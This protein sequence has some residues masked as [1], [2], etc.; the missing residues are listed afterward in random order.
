MTVWVEQPGDGGSAVWGCD[1]CSRGAYCTD[2]TTARLEARAHARTHGTT[3]ITTI[4][5]RH[6]PQPSETRDR[7]IYQLRTQGHTI[8]TIAATVGLSTTGVIKA[9]RRKETA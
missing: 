7:T 6:G 1:A 9:L 2:H 4:G 5:Q 8:R 3:R